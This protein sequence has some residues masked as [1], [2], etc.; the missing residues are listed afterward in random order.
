MKTVL[1]PFRERYLSAQDYLTE[2][3]KDVQYHNIESVH[4]IP[5]KVGHL[6]YGVFKVKYKTPILCEDL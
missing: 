3:R 2:M 6:G 4:F 5:P 1:I